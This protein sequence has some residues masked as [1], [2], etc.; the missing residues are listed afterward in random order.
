MSSLITTARG[1]KLALSTEVQE[2]V[3][4]AFSRAFA[5][6]ARPILVVNSELRGPLSGLLNGQRT[7]MA[8]VAHD[9]LESNVTVDVVARVEI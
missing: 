2:E 9:E 1:R 7:D 3:T 6:T 4:D 5:K 8:I